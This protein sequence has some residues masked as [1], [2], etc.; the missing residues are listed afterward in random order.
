MLLPDQ[1]Y[2]Q[3]S[4]GHEIVASIGHLK[5]LLESPEVAKKI[6][7]ID[8]KRAIEESF[9]GDCHTGDGHEV[10]GIDGEAIESKCVISKKSI[11]RSATSSSVDD[12]DSNDDAEECGNDDEDEEEDDKSEND[13]C[14]TRS[15]SPESFEKTA[16]FFNNIPEF[17]GQPLGPFTR[18]SPDGVA[19]KSPHHDTSV[20]T[21]MDILRACEMFLFKHRIRPDFFCR[22]KK[23]MD[24]S[25]SAPPSWR[26]SR[27]RSPRQELAKK[28]QS[29][30]PPE[31]RSCSRMHRFQKASAIYTLPIRGKSRRSVQTSTEVTEIRILCETLS[32]SCGPNDDGF[33]RPGM[34]KAMGDSG[35][36]L[37]WVSREE[38]EWTSATYDCLQEQQ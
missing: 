12:D 25:M 30:S 18:Q 14:D 32:R 2:E 22:Y 6:L 13:G 4:N 3:V 34:V 35:W 16:N 37:V 20:H 9:D 7:L 8:A 23:A 38:Q 1:T 28:P 19:T 26:T 33:T 29:N 15:S 5:K 27:C 17:A 24:A 10:H 31:Q 11:E 36:V 21:N